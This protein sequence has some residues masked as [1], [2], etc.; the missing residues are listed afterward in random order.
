[1]EATEPLTNDEAR[2]LVEMARKVGTPYT[3]AR[4]AAAFALM[5]RAGLR[6]NEARMLELRDLRR[7]DEWSVRIRHP[8]G[9]E[10]GRAK[11]RE[12]G[13][14]PGCREYLERWL[15]HR[16]DEAGPLFCTEAGERVTLQT[17]RRKVK[18]VARSARIEKRVHLH[19]L[20]HTFA[21]MMLDE[22]VDMRTIQ[23]ALGHRDLSTTATYLASIGNPE[24]I[25]ATAGRTW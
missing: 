4:E 9:I 19:G 3:S 17:W 6:S 14:D 13:V 1:M 18:V 20:R 25:A 10:S 22:G 24:V 12:L 15:V 2:A 8:K 21:R 7:D 11:P 5:V 16:G 23:L